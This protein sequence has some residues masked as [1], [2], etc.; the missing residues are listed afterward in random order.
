MN[1]RNFEYRERMVVELKFFFFNTLFL[2]TVALNFPNVLDF[3][4]F[5]DFSP[6]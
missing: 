4:V 6:S 5:L 1:D 3:H 2:Q